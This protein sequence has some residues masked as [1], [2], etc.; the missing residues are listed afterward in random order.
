MLRD[1]IIV[2]QALFT[3]RF[4][5]ECLFASLIKKGKGGGGRNGSKGGTR[6]DRQTN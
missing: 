5:P 6:E 2:Q 3:Q 4:M 1:H